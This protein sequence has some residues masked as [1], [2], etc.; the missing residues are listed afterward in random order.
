MC[1]P[2]RIIPAHAPQTFLCALA[3]LLS[4]ASSSC[5]RSKC[6]FE[7]PAGSAPITDGL[8]VNIHFTDPRPGE[9]K[10]I[11]DAGFRWVRMDF[12]WDLTETAAGKYDFAPY[13]R[14]LAA[15]EPYHIRA[16]FILDYNN[17]LYD[18]GASP[19]TEEGRQAF[20][21][22][23]AAAA[24]HFQGRGI[25]WE[26]YNEPNHVF[27]R[28]QPNV[29]DY[30]KLALAVGKAMREAAP[31]EILI[32]PAT[33]GVDFAFLEACFKA[34][35]L[36][37]WSAVSVHPYRQ[38][39]PETVAEDYCRLRQL[40][41]AYAPLVSTASD[42]DRASF[43][44]RRTDSLVSTA[45]DSDRVKK[46]ISI[47]SGEWGYSSVWRGMNEEKQGQ[48]LA[49]QWLTNAANDVQISIWYDW[50]D[51]GEDPNDAE[52]H[53]GT[54]SYPAHAVNDASA[55]VYPLVYD[56]KPAYLAA[57]TLTRFFAGYRF[58]KRLQVGGATDYVL[59]FQKENDTRLAVWT[60]SP[61]AHSVV[62]KTSG[63]DFKLI[64]VTA[65]VT[66]L[67][68]TEAVNRDGTK[69]NAPRFITTTHLGKTGPPIAAERDS[70]IIMLTNAPQYLS[71]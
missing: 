42:S 4:L 49:R 40:I 52:D 63:P 59:L 51:D 71:Q 32:G 41:A 2:I 22:W 5:A 39:D 11:A 36:E 21:R 38:T 8:G 35:L 70:L 16:L 47:I 62:I 18:N 43:A 33:S 34:G 67:P 50:H 27:W 60:T 29:D 3:L 9:M 57:Q 66:I 19:R 17:R 10:M 61:I 30:I 1:I 53:F 6:T 25:I 56:A 24:K 44:S 46:Q 28:P 26:M 68:R 37:Y 65:P 23:A 54:V 14:L 12:K 45:S 7:P 20:A 55:P 48:M 64:P 58:V 69:A 13:D 31:G 15:L